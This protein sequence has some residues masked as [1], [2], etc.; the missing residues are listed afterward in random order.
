M[1]ISTATWKSGGCM[2]LDCFLLRSSQSAMMSR[3]GS[4][5]MSLRT[6]RHD[7]HTP[8]H[9]EERS[10]DTLLISHSLMAHCTR[11]DLLVFCRQA[12]SVNGFSA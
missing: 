11:G 12:F 3:G 1:A 6:A 4:A 5:A 8:R 9:C 10:D 7:R 2:H